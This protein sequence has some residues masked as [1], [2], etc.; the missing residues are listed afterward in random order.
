MYYLAKGDVYVIN[1]DYTVQKELWICKRQL[2]I[3][4][5]CWEAVT[6]IIREFKYKIVNTNLLPDPSFQPWG[7]N[8]SIVHTSSWVFLPTQWSHQNIVASHR[9]ATIFMT[10][11]KN[12]FWFSLHIS[13]FQN[14]IKIQHPIY[15][16]CSKDL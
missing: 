10:F 2:V 9:T 3:S 4:C 7:D 15:P 12:L 1:K 11:H 14:Q 5:H 13:K 6:L 16:N 8:H